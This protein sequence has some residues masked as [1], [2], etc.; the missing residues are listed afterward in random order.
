MLQTITRLLLRLQLA[1]NSFSNLIARRTALLGAVLFVCLGVET[2]CWGIETPDYSE[3]IYATSDQALVQ[4]FPKALRFEEKTVTLSAKEKKVVETE[5]GWRVTQTN[6]SVVNAMAED[7]ILGYGIILDELGKHYPIT[8]MVGISPDL[9]VSN[10]VVMVYRERIG[11]KI[12]KRRFL[13]QF[14]GKTLKDAIAVDLDINGISGATISSW[15]V[16][17]GIRRA[18]VVTQV[19]QSRL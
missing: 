10:A 9:S 16:A 11:W 15:A 19:I 12:K 8:F 7:K 14:F 2:A 17:S 4:M 6:Y 3:K 13:K 1:F 18:L 5:L